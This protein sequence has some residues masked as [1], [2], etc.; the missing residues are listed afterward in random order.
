MAAARELTLVLTW[1]VKAAAQ[2]RRRRGASRG[3][4]ESESVLATTPLSV[5]PR[6]RHGPYEPPNV[7]WVVLHM[8]E[9][10]ARHAGHLDLGRELLDGKVRLG[11]RRCG[12]QVPILLAEWLHMDEHADRV[13]LISGSL[14][15]I[16][17]CRSLGQASQTVGVLASDPEVLPQAPDVPAFAGA[18]ERTPSRS[19]RGAGPNCATVSAS[20]LA[21]GDS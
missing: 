5:P 3:A 7:R 20:M 12:E 8:I 11:G 2:A 10:T 14:V 21:K 18:I 13:T 16:G 1:G 9:E 17:T 6:G 19:C 4:A 15:P